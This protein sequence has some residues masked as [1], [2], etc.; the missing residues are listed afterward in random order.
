MDAG[1]ALTLLDLAGLETMNA[2]TDIGVVH[3]GVAKAYVRSWAKHGVQRGFRGVQ[4]Y[5]E[6]F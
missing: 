4:Q 1:R 2:R 5:I 6:P 3:R